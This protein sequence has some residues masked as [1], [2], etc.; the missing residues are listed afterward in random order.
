MIS[1]EGFRFL[2]FWSAGCLLFD[3]LMLKSIISLFVVFLALHRPAETGHVSC[4]PVILTAACCCFFHCSLPTQCG[5]DC[6]V[7]LGGVHEHAY[8]GTGRE[9]D[10]GAFQ[11]MY[12]KLFRPVSCSF[13]RFAAESRSS[14]T[15]RYTTIR[16]VSL[17]QLTGMLVVIPYFTSAFFATYSFVL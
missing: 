10:I 5:E 15:P 14:Q 13:I 9:V 6:E 16:P 7:V 12:S 1:L 3:Y 8:Q 17:H 4:L 2:L 11:G